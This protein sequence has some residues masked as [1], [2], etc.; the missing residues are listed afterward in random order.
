MIEQI[1]FFGLGALMAALVWLILLPAFWRRATRITRAAIESGLPLTANEIAAE[2]DRLR[3]EHA[4]RIGQM[5]QRLDRIRT[6]IVEARRETGERLKAEAK[7]LDTIAER[8]RLIAERE[9]EA[10]GLRSRIADL[11]AELA[12][13]SEARSLAQTTLTGLE[14]QRDALTSKLNSAL[15]QAD[16][17]RHAL[18]EARNQ[19][20]R[21]TTHL[22]EETR[23]NAELRAE[24][25]ARD[26]SLR[27]LERRAASLEND[28]ALARIRRGEVSAHEASEQGREVVARV[29]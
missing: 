12:A 7:Y 1:L 9:V 19:I 20:E 5:E 8:E 18:D 6:D 15:D 21:L 26:I 17:R 2:H 3:A 23:R 29:G 14:I 27:E 11:E 13:L 24:L 28:V 16:E 25:Q 10:T 4:V 22:D